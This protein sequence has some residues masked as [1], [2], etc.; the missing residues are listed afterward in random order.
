[1]CVCVCACVCVCMFVC[2]CVCMYVCAC[3]VRACVCIACERACVN[4]CVCARVYVGMM[5]AHG[6]KSGLTDKP[7]DETSPRSRSCCS[8]ER[9]AQRQGNPCP[10]P[11]Q[12]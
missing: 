1:V 3:G 9:V 4:V 12:P 8:L 5:I 6:L 11:C 7:R 2:V 10:L